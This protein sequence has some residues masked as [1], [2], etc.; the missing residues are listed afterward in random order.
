MP[1]LP[2]IHDTD[3]EIGRRICDKWGLNALEVTAEAF[4]SPASIVFDQA[5]LATTPSE[6]P[7]SQQSVPEMRL[8]V[9]LPI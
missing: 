6:R 5:E 4:E 7:W 1:Y 8:V 3:T 2:A 9:A